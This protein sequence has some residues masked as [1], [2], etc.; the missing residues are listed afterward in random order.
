MGLVLI[1]IDSL[2]LDDMAHIDPPDAGAGD[3]MSPKER[4][5]VKRQLEQLGYV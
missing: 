4:S 3:G 1:T 2:R 5:K